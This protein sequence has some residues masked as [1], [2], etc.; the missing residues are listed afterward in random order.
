[1]TAP[2]TAPADASPRVVV[3]TR[4]GADGVTVL[5][6][7]GELD[8]ST[9]PEALEAAQAALAARPAALVIDTAAVTF[10]DSTGIGLLL[11]V[12]R[13]CRAA[14]VDFT[15]VASADVERVTRVLGVHEAL[16]ARS[17]AP[18]RAVPS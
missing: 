1:M 10:V 3:A 16:T 11:G 9:V 2:E 8:L 5:E 18:D 13:D 15:V 4:T 12:R 14:D 17:D 7:A 6:L